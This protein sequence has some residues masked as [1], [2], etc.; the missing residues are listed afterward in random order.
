MPSC[1]PVVATSSGRMWWSTV[2]EDDAFVLQRHRFKVVNGEA[3]G[4]RI[5]ITHNSVIIAQAHS[6]QDIMSDWESVHQVLDSEAKKATLRSLSAT[7]LKSV[8]EDLWSASHP[9]T[10]TQITEETIVGEANVEIFQAIHSGEAGQL[11]KVLVNLKKTLASLTSSA[12]SST[13]TISLQDRVLE[14]PQMSSPLHVAALYDRIDVCKVLLDHGFDLNAK[15]ID[16]WCPLHIAASKGNFSICKYFLEQKAIGVLAVGDDGTSALHNLA[17]HASLTTKETS[18]L[19]ECLE[20]MLQKGLQVNTQ[21]SL[22][23]TPLHQAALSGAVT[24][25][26]ILLKHN[27][28]PNLSA[29]DGQTPLHLAVRGGHQPVVKILMDNGANPTA[30]SENGTPLQ[31]AFRMS[32]PAVELLVKG[33]L[34]EEYRRVDEASSQPNIQTSANDLLNSHDQQLTSKLGDSYLRCGLSPNEVY[35]DVYSCVHK[36]GGSAPGLLHIFEHYICFI[37]SQSDTSKQII[38]L[39]DVTDIQKKDPF[40]GVAAIAIT[41]SNKKYVFSLYLRDEAYNLINYLF[42]RSSIIS[43]TPLVYPSDTELQRLAKV[44]RVKFPEHHASYLT[45]FPAESATSALIYYTSGTQ[46]KKAPSVRIDGSLYL[47]SQFLCFLSSGKE[48]QSTVI[49]LGQVI[50]L[51]TETNCMKLEYLARSTAEPLEALFEFSAYQNKVMPFVEEAWKT[52]RA[53][54]LPHVVVFGVD[55]PPGAYL[56]KEL[57]KDSPKCSVILTLCY[58]QLK[59][60]PVPNA[61]TY[62]LS[63]NAQRKDIEILLQ[64]ATIVVV[65][66]PHYILEQTHTRFERKEGNNSNLEEVRESL[67]SI[68]VSEAKKGGVSK[69]IMQSIPFSKLEKEND[70]NFAPLPLSTATIMGRCGMMLERFK[71]GEDD[72]IQS[73]MPYCII[74]CNP[75]MQFLPNFLQLTTRRSFKLPIGSEEVSW[76]DAEDFACV[77]ASVIFS[78]SHSG[79][80][81]TL[82]GPESLS[83]SDLATS[84]S[85]YTG[86][87][88]SYTLSIPNEFYN[89]Q[90]ETNSF[91]TYELSSI[92]FYLS[93]WSAPNSVTEPESC[94]NSMFRI[95][96][97]MITVSQFWPK[98]NSDL[99]IDYHRILSGKEIDL[100][101]ARF[102][103]VSVN[104]NNSL[105]KEEFVSSLGEPLVSAGLASILFRAFNLTSRTSIALEDCLTT[106]ALMTRGTQAQQ[107]D[108]SFLLFDRDDKGFITYDDVTRVM[109]CLQTCYQNVGLCCDIDSLLAI[110]KTILDKYNGEITVDDYGKELAEYQI[111]IMYLGALGVTPEKEKQSLMQTMPAAPC[112]WFGCPSWQLVS[113]LMLGIQISTAEVSARPF[114]ENLLPK[115]FLETSDFRLPTIDS[116]LTTVVAEQTPQSPALAPSQS[117]TCSSGAPVPSPQPTC[118]QAVPLQ[119]PRLSN[120]PLAHTPQ[121]QSTPVQ[122]TPPQSLTLSPQPVP[123][124]IDNLD[125]DSLQSPPPEPPTERGLSPA[126]PHEDLQA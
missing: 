98:I 8:F 91:F 70:S 66:Q 75:L 62:C 77:V 58:Y 28:N 44:G 81:Y 105:S 121:S 48:P 119:S 47:S 2:Q 32:S 37:P 10:D 20:L 102:C 94:W 27:A 110:Y 4:Y 79:A 68:I 3:P 126:S 25:A 65:L 96:R 72:L 40:S 73:G 7:F 31:I 6:E 17:T 109:A 21:N 12:S 74:R 69:F 67:F 80:I 34:Q 22:G 100:L 33:A 50:H 122:L 83:G 116:A 104:N 120:S 1:A 59:P 114:Y 124:L 38:A 60:E 90:A 35:F 71:G 101:R 5:M 115:D 63:S 99:H 23:H 51:S 82:Y 41:A 45:H 42:Q 54:T 56:V 103:S 118:A 84:L 61:K 49:E 19:V 113:D 64:E 18:K 111:N 52:Q 53:K 39:V 85:E 107:S 15:D 55:T 88:I 92:Y 123:V 78:P 43:P 57:T 29:D 46:V 106:M 86:Q 97:P 36:S 93:I 95:G 26:Q 125:A 14:M 117:S 112:V 89:G 16:G 13:G 24:V 11:H 9:T 87:N 76:V 30:Q 108:L